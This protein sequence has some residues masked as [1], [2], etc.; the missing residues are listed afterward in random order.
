MNK[1]AV[2]IPIIALITFSIITS[3]LS[4]ALAAA[5]SPTASISPTPVAS[6]TRESSISDKEVTE[7]LKKRLLGSQDIKKED[8]IQIVKGYIGIVKDV[9]KDTVIIEDKD[10]KKDIKLEDNTVIVRSPGNSSIKP[11]SIRID[12][13]I[14]AIGYPSEDSSLT[15]KRLIVSVDP[16]KAPGKT[17]GL[18]TISK[19]SKNS[20]TLKLSDKDQIMNTTTKTIYKSSVGTIEP[21]DLEVGDTVIYTAI[22]DSNDELT[23]TILMRTQTAS[24]AE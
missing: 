3:K 7:N 9:I 24:I 10:G 12:D 16:I 6:P 17:S 15:G 5:P 1:K 13:Y 11:D 22:L 18:G 4:L 14:I 19:I 21:T 2:L 8:P 23:S 20:I